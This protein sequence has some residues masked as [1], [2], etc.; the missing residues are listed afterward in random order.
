MEEAVK[1]D[2]Q[3]LMPEYDVLDKKSMDDIDKGKRRVFTS[4]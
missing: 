3:V 4:G 2:D 1:D